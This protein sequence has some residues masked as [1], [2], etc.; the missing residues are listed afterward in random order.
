[1]FYFKLTNDEIEKLWMI[2]WCNGEIKIRIGCFV[3]QKY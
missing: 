1:M 2:K 3:S